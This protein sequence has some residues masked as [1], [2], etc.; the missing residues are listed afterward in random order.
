[1]SDEVEP[2]C[3]TDGKIVYQAEG[4]FDDG[5]EFGDTAT[6]IVPRLGH[7]WSVTEYRWAEDCSSLTASRTCGND[8]EHH[9]EET[10]QVML[11]LKKMPTETEAGSYEYRIA[12]FENP[13]FSYAKA[14]ETI[15]KLNG[16]LRLPDSTDEIEEEAFAGIASEAVII[17]DG[18]RY[19]RAN[20]F[21]GCTNLRCVSI[22]SDVEE[23]DETA[24]A[25]CDIII[26]TPAGSPAAAWAKTNVIPCVVIP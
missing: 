8:A 20:A 9:E 23:I 14:D 7:D 2:D 25:G 5:T 6:V 10:V 26:I 1:M 12:A 18:C 19:I 15:P 17:P 24:F 22:P 21:A 11:V 3:T 4:A 16:I 13:D